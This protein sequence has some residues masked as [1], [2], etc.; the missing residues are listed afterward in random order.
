[1]ASFAAFGQQFE[2][3]VGDLAALHLDIYEYIVHL[4]KTH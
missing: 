2:T 1:V 3:H 4:K